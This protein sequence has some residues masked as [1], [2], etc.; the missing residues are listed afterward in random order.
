MLSAAALAL[1]S[2]FS[3]ACFNG[4]MDEIDSLLQKR[5][6][7]NHTVDVT[8]SKLYLRH[9]PLSV[10][11]SNHRFEAVQL[12]IERKANID[13]PGKNNL[14]AI[15]C[16]SF[17]SATDTLLPN[18]RETIELLMHHKASVNV[19]TAPTHYAPLHC[20]ATDGNI[21]AL[22][23][24]LEHKADATAVA[25][26]DQ[27]P[28]FLAV[29]FGHAACVAALLDNRHDDSVSSTL[30]KRREKSDNTPLHDAIV[31]NQ[32]PIVEMLLR[33][34]ADVTATNVRLHTALHIAALKNQSDLVATL[35]AYKADCACKNKNQNYPIHLAAMH[36]YCGPLRVLLAHKADVN[37]AG[38]LN[39]TPLHLASDDNHVEAVR[40]LLEYKAD[41][42]AAAD[43]NV[44]PIHLAASDGHVESIA[45]MLEYNVVV[46][47]L[48]GGKITAL[49]LA[50]DGGHPKAVEL[51]LKHKADVNGSRNTGTPLR[52]AAIKGCVPVIDVL[53]DYRADINCVSVCNSCCTEK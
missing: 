5:A 37:A 22:Q 13:E 21:E 53:L 3:L 31:C 7:I 51:L 12:L 11:A 38:F 23:V 43:S 42:N 27:T 10:A 45:V 25:I 14:Q 41:V 26:D 16:A 24:L 4:D 34:K 19:A 18:T 30:N 50:A 39:S 44:A 17:L 1:A 52:M 48:D 46:D 40:L 36:G 9:P 29:R 20:A 33:A 47:A 35:L 28:L 2:D 15:H 8:S 6:N 49:S 32:A